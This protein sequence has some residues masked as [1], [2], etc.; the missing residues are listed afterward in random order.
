MTACGSVGKEAVVGVKDRATKQVR[1][2]VV[3]K[4][5]SATLQGFFVKNTAHDAMSTPMR[6]NP[7]KAYPV[8]MRL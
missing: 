8:T 3:E 1:A 6:R 2:K 5:D 4:T 7:T